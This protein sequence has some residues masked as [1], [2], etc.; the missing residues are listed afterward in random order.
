MDAGAAVPDRGR[1]RLS[2]LRLASSGR[3]SGASL[4]YEVL[5]RNAI[6]FSWWSTLEVR[7]AL[8]SVPVCTSSMFSS[9]VLFCGSE[10]DSGE[11]LA[12]TMCRSQRWLRLRMSLTFLEASL[13]CL[14]PLA[15]TKAWALRV[16]T[17]ALRSGRRRRLRRSPLEGVVLQSRH[18]AVVWCPFFVRVWTGK[19]SCHYVQCKNNGHLY[20]DMSNQQIL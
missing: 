9:Q 2:L 1:R 6:G 11:S 16:K 7:S 5:S 18:V 3:C 12:L 4:Q 8:S 14:L 15:M 17:H 10:E 19:L 13:S 20:V